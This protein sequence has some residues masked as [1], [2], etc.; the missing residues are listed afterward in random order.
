MY[1]MHGVC[2]AGHI[3]AVSII[4]KLWIHVMCEF[5]HAK[6]IYI[7]YCRELGVFH[8]SSVAFR[9]FVMSYI[10]AAFGTSYMGFLSFSHSLSLHPFLAVLHFILKFALAALVFAILCCC[11]FRS[12]SSIDRSIVPAI[13]F[14]AFVVL[15]A[16]AFDLVHCHPV[17]AHTMTHT[18]TRTPADSPIT[19]VNA[20]EYK[21]IHI[22]EY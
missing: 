6:S 21:L 9:I 22:Y 4:F 17:R 7:L 10:L 20:C 19:C 11:F 16:L 14:S 3:S 1:N 8:V 2:V 12:F 15:I 13:H 18:H 5:K